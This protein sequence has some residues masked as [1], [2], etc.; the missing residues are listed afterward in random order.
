G[1]YTLTGQGEPERIVGG[2]TT[3][4]FLRVLGI[5]P[6][7]GRFFTAEEDQPGAPRLAVLSYAA[8]QR[9]FGASSD[10]LGSTLMLDSMPFTIIGVLP[11][12]FALPG[13]RTCEFFAALREDP[14]NG[15]FQHQYGVL[16]RLKP[17]VSVE[18]AQAN[19]TTIT[20]RL[21]QEYPETNKGWGAK[22]TPIREAIATETKEPALILFSAV[23]FVLLLACANVAGL[24]L[25]RAS[26]RA[27][28]MA[29]RASLGGSR[30]RL[31]CQMLTESLLLAL[32]GGVLGLFFAQWLMDVLRATAPEDF[33]LDAT[34]RIDPTVL[35]F[36][37]AISMLTGIVFGLAPAL[38]GSK[39]D[40][41]SAIKGDPN[42]WSGARTRGRFM[43]CLIAGEVTLSLV[44]LVGAGLLLKDLMVVLRLQ[45][46]LHIEH[47]LTFALDPPHAR[48]QSP[49]GVAPFYRD[50]LDR[51]RSTTGVDMAAVVSNLPMTGGMTGGN[52]QVEGR[53]KA[54]DWVDTLVEYNE[55]TPGFFLALGIP[56]LRGRDFDDRDS[57]NSLPVAVI[58]DT[59]AKQ[60]FPNEDPIG[61]RFKDSYAGNW[62]TI[63]GVVGSYKHQQPMNPPMPCVFRP[64]AQTN[65]G[66]QWVAVRTRSNP[67]KLATS[68]R[69]IVHAIDPDVP[70][71]RLR[72]MRQVV[73]DSLSESRLMTQF[74]SGFAGFALLLAVIGIYGI[75]A[76]SVRQ[77]LHEMGIRVA[78][79][80]S[81]RSLLS[82]VM[83]RG[84]LLVALGAFVG[85]PL[86]LALSKVMSS[87]LYGISPRDLT[88]FVGVPMLLVIVA[89]LACYLPARR[90]ASVNPIEALRYE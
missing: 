71:M 88:I 64:L 57:A 75:V 40:L 51:L 30:V 63:V 86:A 56:L 79:G 2:E 44:S 22:V 21:E 10:V 54:E 34:L 42:L 66:Y 87:I 82:L 37:L 60:F 52:F 45:T 39:S 76:Y 27:K 33:A 12:G 47:V 35:L 73:A 4:G 80:A 9:R 23:F 36:T 53:A 43:S 28:E 55:S 70:V 29:V 24:Q 58:N 41:N 13:V 1:S 69:G 3:Y 11:R 62:R 65:F 18:L 20:S 72:T 90:A 48:Y 6:V 49:Q 15:R 32:A 50:L 85:I 7:L 83:R 78:L 26:A 89:L 67:E 31:V 17:G 19:M 46:G 77:R 5:Q 14:S 61:Q 16:A 38:Y 59:L 74:L 81:Y 8:W 84:M 25:A 68:I